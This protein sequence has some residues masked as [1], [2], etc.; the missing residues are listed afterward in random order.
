MSDDPNFRVTVDGKK[1]TKGEWWGL[2][3]EVITENI[4]DSYLKE[5]KR[6]ELPSSVEKILHDNIRGD[7]RY[8]IDT[9]KSCTINKQGEFNIPLF[10]PLET[11]MIQNLLTSTLKQSI[12][13]QKT[14]GGS[15]IQASDYGVADKP[16][17]VLRGQEKQKD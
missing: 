1:L 16:K 4:L 6:F 2:Y 11:Q 7:Q 13:K 8:G 17:I 10:E 14:K 3:N 9:L 5:A 12:T 15:L